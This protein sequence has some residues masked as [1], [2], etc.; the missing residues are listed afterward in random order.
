MNI[1][2]KKIW[3]NYL[4]CWEKV[5]FFLW[6]L[7]SFL[8]RF[9]RLYKYW[10]VSPIELNSL[11]YQS[12]EGL[13]HNHTKLWTDIRNVVHIAFYRRVKK[14]SGRDNNSPLLWCAR[15]SLN[16]LSKRDG[17]VHVHSIYG[18]RVNERMIRIFDHWTSSFL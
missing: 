13:H 7:T 5:V 14:P 12:L 1:K 17:I 18:T 2:S 16:E 11:T 3:W 6:F 15:W 9:M 4:T 10:Q 8:C